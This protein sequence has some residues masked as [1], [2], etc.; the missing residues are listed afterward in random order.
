MENRPILTL[1][2][3]KNRLNNLTQY[4]LRTPMY[5]SIDTQESETDIFLQL[6]QQFTHPSVTTARSI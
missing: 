5:L 3:I 4:V 1:E 2:R 6:Q